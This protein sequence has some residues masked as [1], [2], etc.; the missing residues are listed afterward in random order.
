[1]KIQDIELTRIEQEKGVLIVQSDFREIAYAIDKRRGV[2]WIINRQ[3]GAQ[4]EIA[5]ENVYRFADE[6][7]SVADVHMRMRKGGEL[8]AT[9]YFQT[10]SGKRL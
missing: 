6:L 8:W 5:A 7:M 10:T 9:T 4:L 3:T 2:M 1:M